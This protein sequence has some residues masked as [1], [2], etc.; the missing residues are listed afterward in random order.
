MLC[1]GSQEN[2]SVVEIIQSAILRLLLKQNQNK[3][4]QVLKPS[5]ALAFASWKPFAMFNFLPS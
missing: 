2:G 5:I 3:S 4:G 1:E